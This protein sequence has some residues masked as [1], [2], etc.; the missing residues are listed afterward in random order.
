MD[1]QLLVPRE[2][3]ANRREE[4]VQEQRLRDM[5]VG[6]ELLRQG[7]P[8][9]LL[10]P[11]TSQ[12]H[13]VIRELKLAAAT[14]SLAGDRDAAGHEFARVR[15]ETVVLTSP[16]ASQE[17][18]G[19]AQG[20]VPADE[21]VRPGEVVAEVLVHPQDEILRRFVESSGCVSGASGI[22]GPQDLLDRRKDRV[23]PVAV[24][25]GTGR[26]T[27]NRLL[28]DCE[29]F[30]VVDRRPQVSGVPLDGDIKNLEGHRNALLRTDGPMDVLHPGILNGLKFDG[31]A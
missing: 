31:L 29:G 24:P 19:S 15:P 1:A 30:E 21:V 25:E 13:Q 11:R 16:S 7:T 8:S 20:L 9:G 18:V 10:P 28:P 23:L 12:L 4:L 3:Q 6:G 27:P 17:D 14:A 22:P 26:G 5:E 2:K